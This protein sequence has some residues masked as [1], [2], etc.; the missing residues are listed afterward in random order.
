[1]QGNRRSDTQPEV[2]LRRLLHA[3][4]FRYRKDHSLRANGVRVRADV[5]FTRQRLAVF[6]D[7]C[8]WHGCPDHCRMP[9]SNVA[10]WQAKIGRN[11]AR[12]RR[13]DDALRGDGWRV[14]RFWE[15]VPVEEAAQAVT[16]AL[17]G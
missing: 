8:F 4:G 17:R 15:H 5:V 7:G 16:Q 9:G 1:M 3:Q 11:R 12:D 10:Y 14:L 13:I 6:V 2:A